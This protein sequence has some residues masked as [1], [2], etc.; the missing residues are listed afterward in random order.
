MSAFDLGNNDSM[1]SLRSETEEESSQA[2]D[3]NPETP[4]AQEVTH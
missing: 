3:A 1:A 2:F 4:A